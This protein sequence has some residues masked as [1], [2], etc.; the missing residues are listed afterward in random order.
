[1]PD[2]LNI[3]SSALLSYQRALATTGHNIS[4]ANVEGYSRQRTEFTARPPQFSG[5]GFIGSGVSIESIS[6]V[7]DQFR[8]EQVRTN[9]ASFSQ[10]DQF[11][12]LAAQVDNILADP[13]AGL[14]PAL[15]SF[16]NSL[17]DLSDDPTSTPVR[18]IVLSE[19]E[20]LVQRFS[21]LDER[22]RSL[23]ND[24]E[25]DITN[26]VADI[27]NISTS[28]ANI[29]QD[30]ILST[31][32]NGQELPNDLLDERDRLVLQLSELVSTNT[33]TQTDGS[34]NVF[35]GS[36]QALV[37]GTTASQLVAIPGEF[38]AARQDIAI[39]LGATQS[40]ITTFISGGRL[41]AT[42]D[43][44]SQIIDPGLNTLGRV[45]TG[46]GALFNAQQN[47]GL[48]QQDALGVNLFALGPVNVAESTNNA[49][50]GTPT[51]TGAL[52]NVSSLTNSDYRLD[53]DGA[54]YSVRRLNDDVT[55]FTGNLATLNAT[56][57]DGFQLTVGAGAAAGDS[58]T[59]QPTSTGARDLDLLFN[60]PSRLAAAAPLRTATTLANTGDGEISLL[61]V[62]NVTQIPLSANGGDIILTFDPDA[63]GVGVPGFTV[64]GGPG[65][66]LAYDPAT[67]STGKTFTLGAPF[68][69]IS[70]TVEGVTDNGDAL[71]IT[72]N[73][74]GV[75][76]NR[77][78]LLLAGLESAIT[79]SGNNTF[80]SAYGELVAD[81]GIRTQQSFLTR[82]AQ[83]VLL[84]QSIESREEISGVNLDEEAADLVR[85]QQAFQAA[86]QVISIA[87]QLFQEILQAVR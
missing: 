63:L 69:G 28:I 1:M 9:T 43:F 51:V 36:G 73:I 56:V 68:D 21:T 41:G 53:F 35:V 66:T 10:V 46:L 37:V 24:A 4:N 67:E 25:R 60:D 55:L 74:N 57:I 62:N 84:D 72:D 6:R 45:A 77:N 85:L 18:Q 75:G 82:D 32:N 78:A 33:I 61:P 14:S 86:A 2:I 39:Q 87:D 58:F 64:T 15:Q 40:N 76:D 13:N 31:R 79:L 3:A 30:I 52:V 12:S 22:L 83:Q 29:N 80:Q 49:V 16:F 70:F 47:L 5:A 11:A 17:Q 27:N 44:R 8:V 19:A 23:G 54:N 38:G 26:I 48:D 50:G 65:G 7:Y 81:V 20:G 71:T 34:L 59:I 42:L